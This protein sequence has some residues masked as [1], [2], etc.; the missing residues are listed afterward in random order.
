L[1]LLPPTSRAPRPPY[2]PPRS[3]VRRPTL[4]IRG[5]EG[6]R[7]S[8]VVAHPTGSGIVSRRA[9][10]PTSP[11]NQVK[12]ELVEPVAQSSNPC[13]PFPSTARR[14]IA[15]MTRIP[16]GS[17]VRLVGLKNPDL[18]GQPGNV[19][20]YTPDGDR[21]MVALTDGPQKMVKVK[22]KQIELA[23]EQSR[24][25]GRGG[26]PGLQRNSSTRSNRDRRR[27]RSRDG[28]NGSSQRG[29]NTNRPNHAR[30]LRQSL[31]HNSQGSM[32]RIGSTDQ[33]RDNASHASNVSHEIM[34][35]L[36]SADAMF[37]LADT[38]GDGMISQDEFQYY[39]EKHTNHD[40]DMI[41]E[42]FFMIDVDSNGDITRDEVRNAFLKK[43]R[44]MK[45]DTL[46]ESKHNLEDTML[47]V[48]RDADAL[49]DRADYDGSGT[50]SMREFS[51]YMKR[52]TTHSDYAIQ[53]LFK[54]M[55]ID[56]DGF[57]TR[58]EV[59]KAYMKNAKGEEGDDN[60]KSLADLLGLED[61]EMAEIE[62]DV[63]NMFF[64]AET[65]S[66]G[67][68]FSIV[69][70][71]LKIGLI[72]IIAIDLYTTG[73]FPESHEVPPLVK[74]A[75]FLLLPVNV[76]V[77]E[78]LITTFF[79]Y[80]NLKW[81]GHILECNRGA[82]KT[83]YHIANIMRFVDGVAFLFI[84]TTLLLQATQVLGA[85]L[86]FAALQFLSSIDNVA[87][88]LA[89]DG[90]LSD[91]LESV[92]KDVLLM[93]LPR[94]HNEKLQVLDSVLLA[95]VYFGTLAAWVLFLFVF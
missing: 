86:N 68:W 48:S 91:G 80:A 55:D 65:C 47:A 77:Q 45:G 28:L 87:L 44:Q 41:R 12:T 72:L 71:L 74:T 37:E 59:R 4:P 67:Y 92:A 60:K 69:V 64:L 79:I 29:M 84:N 83:K 11:R 73:Y 19:A 24:G 94:N 20:R 25:G 90:Y 36:R 89:R 43:R 5:D 23:E 63:Y 78:E 42:A 32:R 76:S 10:E 3:R 88:H 34:D 61:D 35:T 40:E 81:S 58:E 46:T 39:M 52:H 49:F 7:S 66:Q 93:K 1:L 53:E 82:S 14:A 16:E 26:R 30:S 15:N 33:F 62:D 57:I 8:C 9:S 95:V 31:G 50:L 75:Q 13:R 22:P 27:S 85:M 21:V 2:L 54:S 6:S 56:N 38:S 70:F 17:K 18:N 51:L